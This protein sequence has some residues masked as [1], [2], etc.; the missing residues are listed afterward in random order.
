MII[1]D[2]DHLESMSQETSIGVSGSAGVAVD[3]FGKA[4]GKITRTWAGT[5]TIVITLPRGGSIAIGAGLV[6]AIAFTPPSPH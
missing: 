5:N 1:A 4:I 2:L 6:V 3:V